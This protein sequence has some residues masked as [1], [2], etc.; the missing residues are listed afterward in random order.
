LAAHSAPS[1]RQRGSLPLAVGLGDGS[2]RSVA[3]AGGSW[4][5]PA[6]QPGCPGGLK[7]LFSPSPPKRHWFRP[8]PE[9]RRA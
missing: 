2:D 3:L 8:H 1:A 5:R 4:A 7:S 6:P 9:C